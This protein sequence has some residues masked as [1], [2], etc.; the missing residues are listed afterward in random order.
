MR[1]PELLAP[2]G[3]FDMLYAAIAA[4]ADSIYMGGRQ[5]GARAFASNFDEGELQRAI[6][7]CHFHG[8]KAYITVNTILKD[9]ELDEGLRYAQSLYQMDADA[10]ILQDLGLA[11]ELHNRFPDLALHASTQLSANTKQTLEQ[12]EQMGFSR[13]ILARELRYSEM[14]DL[15]SSTQMETEVFVHGSLCVS[16]SGKCLMSSFLGGR[17]GNRGRCAQPCRQ[18][19]QIQMANGKEQGTRGPLISPRDLSLYEDLP[20]LVEVGV[21]SLK[22]EG[23]MK[24]PEYVYAVVQSY[25]NHLNGQQ[26]HNPFSL[27]EVSNRGFTKGVFGDAYGKDY[28]L[29]PQGGG[30]GYPVG[31]VEKKGK[32]RQIRFTQPVSRGDGLELKLRRKK[33][34]LTLTES[35]EPGELLL[36]DG[37]PDAMEGSIVARVSNVRLRNMDFQGIVEEKRKPIELKL[38]AHVGEVPRLEARGLGHRIELVGERA[39][40]KANKNPLDQS[41]AQRQLEKLK[42]SPFYLEN[43]IVDTDG[44][45]YMAVSELNGLRR[46]AVEELTAAISNRNQRGVPSV[47]PLMVNMVRRPPRATEISLHVKKFDT[48]LL[49]DPLLDRIVTNGIEDVDPA[50]SG[51]E[52]LLYS[53]PLVGDPDV[54]D[55]FHGS[56][57]PRS[58]I[59][60]NNLGDFTLYNGDRSITAGLGMQVS[61]HLVINA[62]RERGASRFLLSPELTLEEM[63]AIC[64]RT[65]DRI[66]VFVY[67]RLPMMILRNCPAAALIDCDRICHRCRFQRGHHLVDAEKRS[68]PFYREGQRT[69]VL[70]HLAISG[71][72]HIDRLRM[73]GVNSLAISVESTSEYEKIRPLIEKIRKGQRIDPIEIRE[74]LGPTGPGHYTMP[75]D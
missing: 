42:D 36:L 41:Q 11:R 49:S 47:S 37:Y 52:K 30:G 68:F 28:Y 26:Q 43:L 3:S 57:G 13:V 55:R 20:K 48:A 60:A 9:G 5:F 39:L 64:Q 69:I 19:Y 21:H 12:L 38:Q 74:K 10:L 67:G 27:E 16:Y 18:L 2:A 75:I 8:L 14:L 24:K 31:V 65:K 7:L 15:V 46:G 22:I 62:L 56:F 70:S 33:I 63:E 40:E 50:L 17:S 53:M 66:E 35:G 44:A 54:L 32:G 58:G 72:E 34:P 25:Q 61:N 51:A 1:K 29:Q 6:A 45:S 71:L 59:Y 4:G 73:M 23:R